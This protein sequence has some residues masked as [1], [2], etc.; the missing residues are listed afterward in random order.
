MR[1][2]IT[3]LDVV[4]DAIIT[5][6]DG[7]I[8]RRRHLVDATLWRHLPARPAPLPMEPPNWQPP[9]IIPTVVLEPDPLAPWRAYIET[10]DI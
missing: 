7:P 6:A 10:L 8:W 5:I 4:L 3:L 9:A 1:Y 2:L